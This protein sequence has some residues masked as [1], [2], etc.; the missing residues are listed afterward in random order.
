MIIS[1][2]VGGL[3]NQMFEYAHGRALSLR[4]NANLKL[5]LSDYEGYVPNSYGELHNGMAL[6]NG[7]ELKNIFNCPIEIATNEEI[8]EIIGWRSNKLWRK[9]LQKNYLSF[10]RNSSF[11]V[12][13]SKPNVYKNNKKNFFLI[14]YWQNQEFFKDFENQ[15]RVDFKFKIPLDD[16]NKLYSEGIESSNSVSL[17][18]RRGD[19]LSNPNFNKSYN[20]CSLDYYNDAISYIGNH[21]ENPIFYIF[22]DSMSWVKDNL[23]IPYNHHFVDCNGT[24]GGHFDMHL[25]SLCKHNIIANSSFSWWGAWL[26][27]KNTKIVLAPKNWFKDKSFDLPNKWISL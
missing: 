4:L 12:E 7:F 5:D 26:N 21:V 3:G 22:S 10:L 19:Y 18:V 2:I 14:G 24:N 23:N 11:V 17:H 25:M 16:N 15:I 8:K 27:N 1:N 9:N 13:P 20:V 6:H